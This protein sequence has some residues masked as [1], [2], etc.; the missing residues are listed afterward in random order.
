[1]RSCDIESGQQALGM[2]VVAV[3]ALFHV[4]VLALTGSIAFTVVPP[5]RS[6][7]VHV[8]GLTRHTIRKT[9]MQQVLLVVSRRGL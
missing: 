3:V 4:R 9:F 7:R 8:F 5:V 6:V 2:K 1:M